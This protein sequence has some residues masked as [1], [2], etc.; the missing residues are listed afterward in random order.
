MLYYL[1]QAKLKN[2]LN[3]FLEEKNKEI[4]IQNKQIKE[5]ST[6]LEELNLVKNK[7]ISVM[8]HDVKSPMASLEMLLGM[9]EEQNEPEVFRSM[10]GEIK[11]SVAGLMLLLENILGWAKSQM[12]FSADVPMTNVDVHQAGQEIVKLYEQ[13]AEQK[14]VTLKNFIPANTIVNAN[15]D[16]LSLV[17]RNLVSN[18]IKFSGSGTTVQLNCI[19]NHDST[20]ISVEDSGVGMSNEEIA[21]LFNVNS[22][23]TSKGTKNEKGTGLGL[24]FVKESLERCGGT[25][26][27]KSEKHKGSEF[28]CEFRKY[29]N[30]QA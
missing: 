12:Q 17:L 29:H 25:L 27:I 20:S 23:Y 4:E 10:M 22:L 16:Y 21:R 15:K 30:A 3:S 1:R 7:V 14:H 2:R 6:K 19:D 5:Q 11:T 13:S 26:S 24:I 18:A 8:S 9:A 28:I